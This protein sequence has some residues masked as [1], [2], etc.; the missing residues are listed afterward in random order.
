[1][2]LA[3]SD[4]DVLAVDGSLPKWDAPGDLKRFKQH[5]SHCAVVMGR[6]TFE[7]LPRLLPDR[8]HYVLTRLEPFEEDGVSFISSFDDVVDTAFGA[9][10][11][12][13]G[14]EIYAKA[15]AENRITHVHLTRVHTTLDTV[16]ALVYKP[17]L[18]NFTLTHCEPGDKVTFEIWSRN[19][20]EAFRI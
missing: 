6:K 3:L 17:D 11:V 9:S 15:L 4:N 5:T 13:G 7:T 14:A 18:T 12:I 19:K 8:K 16:N 2:I 1:M 20:H 10:W